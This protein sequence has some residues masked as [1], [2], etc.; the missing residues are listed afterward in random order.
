MH[1]L[2]IHNP[3]QA[4]RGYNVETILEL[5]PDAHEV[6]AVSGRDAAIEV[7]PGTLYEPNYP[8]EMLPE[9]VGCFLSHR[10]CWQRIV[11]EGWDHAL[12]VED[13]MGLNLQLYDALKKILSRN[14]NADSFIRLPPENREVQHHVDDELDGLKLITPRVIGLK[15]TAQLVGRNAAKR[16]LK[17]SEKIDRPLDRFIQMHWVTGQR[18]QAIQPMAVIELH[19]PGISSIVEK[20][21]PRG[22][23]AK[24]AW[25]WKRASYRSQIRNRPQEAYP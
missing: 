15:S 18:V 10:T 6:T 24:L 17:A 11:D 12:I 25:E 8:F 5:L 21:K 14:A 22:L 16:L 9:E 4:E 23:G 3:Q 2:V 19:L 13:D 1:T 7:Q 20:F